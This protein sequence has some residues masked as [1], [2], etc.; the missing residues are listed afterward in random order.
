MEQS[1]IL[2]NLRIEQLTPMQEAARDAYQSDKDLVLLSP[3]GSGKTL[4]FLLP[5]VQSLKADVQGVQAVVLVPSREL[6]LQIDESFAAYG[7]GLPLLQPGHKGGAPWPTDAAQRKAVLSEFVFDACGA[8]PNWN[9]ENFIADQV[10]LIRR[11]VGDKKVLLALSG[12]VDSSVVAALLI[13]AIGKQL[14]C[15]H[16]YPCV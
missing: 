7:C 13:K 11:Q 16:V 10:E 2:R 4:A 14:V 3:T 12:G 8:Q 9:M 1:D 5:L 6:A 15:V